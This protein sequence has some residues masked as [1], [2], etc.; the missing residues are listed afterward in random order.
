MDFNY[1]ENQKLISEMIRSF[2]AKE[3]VPNI[4]EWD[5]NQIFPVH[6]FKKLGEL[7]LMGVLVPQEYGGSGFGYAEYVTAIEELAKADPSVGLSMAAHNSLC[8]GHIMQ[9]GNEDQKKKYL[10]KLASAE[11]LGAWGLT[12]HNT[13][14]DSGGMSTTA[15]KNGDDWVLNGA[16]NFITHAISGDVSVVIVRTGEKGD[17]KGMS[18][19]IVEKGIPGLTSGK[20]EDKL[21]MRASETAELIFD[22]CRV[23]QAN[24]LGNV[25]DGFVQAMKV[26]D[27][28][29]ISIAALSLGI[30]KGAYEAALK[31]AKERV[32]F[33]KPIAQHQAIAFKLADMATAIEA[34]ELLIY[35]AVGKKNANQKV[36]LDG[37]M[38]KYYSSEVAV[39]VSTDAI[40]VLGGYGYTKDF[41]VERFYRDSK[42]CTI[43][44]GTSEIQKIVIAKQILK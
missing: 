17:S 44:E 29:R 12:E 25:G 7:G 3:I 8:T 31:Y 10:P 1:N 23:P 39:K 19:F 16:K 9:F 34:S 15:I 22:N 41:P 27:G 11:Y 32:Q 40:Q 30:A 37:A 2:S 6:V 36:T 33:G 26:L 38:A 18:A 13:G 20:K 43:G 14:S 28:G 21:G 24:L 4:K 5:D 35:K 42:L